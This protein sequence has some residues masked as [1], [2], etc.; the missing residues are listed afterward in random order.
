[1][2][3]LPARAA[4]KPE[5]VDGDRVLFLGNTLIEREPRYGYW[6]TALTVA[7]PRSGP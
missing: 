3:L 2:V 4:A 1:V 7:Y 6:E 5:L